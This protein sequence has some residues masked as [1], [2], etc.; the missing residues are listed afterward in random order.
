MPQK[1]PLFYNSFKDNY[2]VPELVNG[3]ISINKSELLKV[4]RGKSTPANFD[5]TVDVDGLSGASRIVKPG[6]H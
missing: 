2:N 5:P 1:D 4:A 6:L 3:A